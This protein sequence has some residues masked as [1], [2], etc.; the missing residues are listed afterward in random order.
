MDR[1][2]FAEKS[3]LYLDVGKPE[4]NGGIGT[5]TNSSEN[6]SAAAI[7]D[8]SVGSH[9]TSLSAFANTANGG[10]PVH[11]LLQQREKGQSKSAKGGRNFENQL[12]LK[13]AIFANMQKGNDEESKRKELAK[14]TSLRR[15]SEGMSLASIRK[16]INQ[17]ESSSSGEFDSSEL[18][19]LGDENIDVMVHLE[20]VRYVSPKKNPGRLAKLKRQISKSVNKL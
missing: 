12:V 13:A 15:N 2:R 16:A 1:S 18:K 9:S 11:A 5:I 7:K 3:S 20:K 17:A 6:N 19:D 10:K 14:L 8:K 4:M